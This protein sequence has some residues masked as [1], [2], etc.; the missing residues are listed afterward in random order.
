MAVSHLTDT[1]DFAP[2]SPTGTFERFTT[3]RQASLLEKLRQEHFTGRLCFQDSQGIESTL[4]L[5]AGRIA[6][7]TGGIHPLRRWCRLLN[8]YCSNISSKLTQLIDGD[9]PVS[10]FS[11]D[12]GDSLYQ[13]LLSWWYD[14]QINRIQLKLV[15]KALAVEV[16][17]DLSLVGPISYFL[18]PENVRIAPIVLVDYNEIVAAAWKQ[19]QQ[20]QSLKLD[21]RRLNLAPAT[22]SG[23]ALQQHFSRQ[24]YD[25]I[26]RYFDGTIPL[27][28]LGAQFNRDLDQLAKIVEIYVKSGCVK[29]VTASDLPLPDGFSFR[30]PISRSRAPSKASI[31]FVG[32]NSHIFQVGKNA[33]I[34]AGCHWLSFQRGREAIAKF[35]LDAPALIFLNSD[36]SDISGFSACDKIRKIETLKSVPIV[37]LGNDQNS[38]D[39]LRAKLSGASQLLPV[40][41]S[42]QQIAGVIAEYV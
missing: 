15:I 41:P 32:I 31:A 3:A 28:D 38:V 17:N 23:E 40:D 14:K 20:W 11:S 36:L 8:Q 21:P 12:Y 24:N 27:R 16:L 10:N 19:L 13:Q 33:A 1:L 9:V 25:S 29:L 37:I 5:H 30:A 2:N 39:R 35:S 4:Y 18:L 42:E 7:A 22:V 26:V 34:A 6:Y